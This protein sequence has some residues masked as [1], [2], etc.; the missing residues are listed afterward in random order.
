MLD[1][2]K[3]DWTRKKTC[4]CLN[5]AGNNLISASTVTGSFS[6]FLFTSLA[7][8]PVGIT[9]SAIGSKICSIT[10]GINK[11]SQL[12]RKKEKKHDKIVLLGK[13]KLDTIEVLISNSLI[14]SLISHDDFFFSK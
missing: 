2:K 8:I 7:A 4:K 6:V 13:T 5:Y 9:S 3:I 1:W 14:D 12:K 11:L 10:A